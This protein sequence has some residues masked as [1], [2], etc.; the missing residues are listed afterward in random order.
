MKTDSLVSCY[1]SFYVSIIKIKTL[2]TSVYDA[3]FFF[4][5]LFLNLFVTAVESNLWA[6]FESNQPVKQQS[7]KQDDIRQVARATEELPPSTDNTTSSS[8]EAAASSSSCEAAVRK[9]E[10]VTL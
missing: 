8:C 4:K 6:A 10:I 7:N 2:A 1:F 5:F 9:T 3:I